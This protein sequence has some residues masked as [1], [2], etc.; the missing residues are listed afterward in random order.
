MCLFVFYDLPLYRIMCSF[1]RERIGQQ[2]L[3]GSSFFCLVITQP[4]S[5]TIK[6]IIKGDVCFFLFLV[7]ARASSLQGF[8]LAP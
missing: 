3:N 7:P 5:F 1:V 8:I 2:K 4:T 6:I